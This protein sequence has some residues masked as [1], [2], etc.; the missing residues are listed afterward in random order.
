MLLPLVAILRLPPGCHYS[1]TRSTRTLMSSSWP[2][3]WCNSGK[4]SSITTTIT[5]PTDD[6]QHG[7]QQYVYEPIR[8]GSCYHESTLSN[9][10]FFFLNIIDHGVRSQHTLQEALGQCHMHT[11]QHTTATSRIGE[12]IHM[13][14]STFCQISNMPII[15]TKS[16]DIHPA[17]QLLH[18]FTI[19]LRSTT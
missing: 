7:N 9:A 2:A 6:R 15:A 10:E 12:N 4:I 11:Q 1:R 14:P 3:C 19:P 16:L 13:P 8:P 18:N 5:E 17:H